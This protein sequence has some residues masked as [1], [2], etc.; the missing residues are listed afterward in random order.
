MKT[1]RTFIR[2]LSGFGGEI[3]KYIYMFF[4]MVVIPEMG[5]SWISPFLFVW[6]YNLQLVSTVLYAF[7]KFSIAFE[8]K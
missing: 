1:I 7:C 6:Y 3:L 2:K 8:N 5:L 4:V